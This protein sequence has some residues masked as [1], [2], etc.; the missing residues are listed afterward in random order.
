M[1]AAKRIS[2][3]NRMG[4][5]V[6]KRRSAI[7]GLTRRCPIHR[8]YLVLRLAHARRSTHRLL[9]IAVHFKRYRAVMQPAVSY[10]ACEEVTAQVSSISLVRYRTND[11]SVLTQYRQVLVLSYVYRME[12]ICGS[13][14]IARHQ[15]SYE[16]ETAV[17]VRCT[18]WPCLNARAGCW[19]RLHCSPAG[20]RPS[21]VISW[22]TTAEARRPGVHLG[23]AVA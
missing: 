19:I 22:S 5:Y 17:Y 2:K 21:A 20:N 12:I 1:L 13:E 23:V 18:T 8:W 14:V 7:T 3:R 11:Y 15:R 4:E 10:E 16:R 6:G 9:Q